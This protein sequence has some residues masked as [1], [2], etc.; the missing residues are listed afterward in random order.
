M[1]GLAFVVIHTS[2]VSSSESQQ[3][4]R[5]CSPK[6]ETGKVC[7]PAAGAALV[8]Q[9]IDER[10]QDST[11]D[12][13]QELHDRIE[14]LERKLSALASYNGQLEE[15]LRQSQLGFRR[16]RSE[17]IDPNQL[18]MALTVP[19]SAAADSQTR[20]CEDT[21]GKQSDEPAATQSCESQ[22]DGN[23]PADK[24][25]RKTTR[26]G[27][28]KVGVIPRVI[29]QVLPPEVLVDGL[30]AFEQIG[31][32]DASLIGFRRGGPL[33]IV[34]R[35]PKFVRRDQSSSRSDSD[36]QPDTACQ[37][38]N[39]PPIRSRGGG[40]VSSAATIGWPSSRTTP[41]S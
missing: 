5:P 16:H 6:P 33:E 19:E 31:Y 28:R 15:A 29:V 17:R 40:P 30:E 39:C 10:A 22:D 11:P 38:S 20:A 24:P 7:H 23:A 14:Q 21:T 41:V 37:F 9:Y 12:P 3:Q 27:R 2:V 36:A 8:L 26:H 13:L 18:H 35:R 1:H 32:E 4:A 34:V 25:K